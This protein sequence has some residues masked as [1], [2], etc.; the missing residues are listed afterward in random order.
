MKLTPRS[1]IVL[2]KLKVA[3]LVTKFSAFLWTLEGSLPW[4]GRPT[5]AHAKPDESSSHP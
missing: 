3:Q 2:G 4:E 5:G 1:R